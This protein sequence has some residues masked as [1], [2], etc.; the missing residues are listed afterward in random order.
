MQAKKDY[1]FTFEQYRRILRNA[2][3]HGFSFVNYRQIG[4]ASESKKNIIL[5]HDIDISL[6]KALAMAEVEH[7]ERVTS[8]YFIML[9]SDFYNTHT[10]SARTILNRITHLGH[11]IG[12][13]FD[14]TVYHDIQLHELKP[15]IDNELDILSSIAGKEISAVSFHRPSQRLL[16]NDL[17]LGEV[18]NTYARRFFTE[19][20]YLSDSRMNWSEIT[21]DEAITNG[22]HPNIQL[23][24]HPI[25]WESERWTFEDIFLLHAARTVEG[26]YS[27]FNNNIRNLPI[28]LSAR[29]KEAFQWKRSK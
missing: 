8:T 9:S 14:E 20:K 12:L 19:I 16:E 2:K 22:Q 10:K 29:F 13:H 26:L 7:E 5:R 4:D 27:K 18:V 25:W 24:I 15:F 28:E 23:L 6:E 11:D 3:Q 21:I 1:P 17:D